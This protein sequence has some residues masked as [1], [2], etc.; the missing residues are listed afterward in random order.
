MTEYYKIYRSAEFVNRHVELD[1]IQSRLRQ[2][3][4]GAFIFEGERGAGKTSLMF[5]I[6]RQLSAQKEF[7]P[8]FIG[9]F[10]YSAPEF[11]GDKKV[12][13][14]EE[15]N[16][17]D[18]FQPGEMEALLEQLAEALGDRPVQTGN[19]ENKTEYLKEYLAR[20]LAR[21]PASA[22]PVL[23]VDSI[24]EADEN[25]RTDVEKYIVAPLLASGRVFVI[26]SGRGKR[27]VWSRPE[28]QNAE[29]AHLFPLEN[30]EQVREQLE[31]MKSKRIGEYETIFDLSGGYP[32]IVRVMGSSDKS[33]ELA[34]Y[35]ALEILIK[36]ALPENAQ[37]GQEFDDIRTQI[38]KLAL[39]QIPFRIPDV[40]NYLYELDP[41]GNTNKLVNTLLKSHILRH[42]GKGYLLNQSIA[43]PYRKWLSLAEQNRERAGL[44]AKL[45][46][47]SERLQAQY[48]AARSWY[49]QMVPA[50]G[51]TGGSESNSSNPF[52]ARQR[53]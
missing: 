35:D 7:T 23:L 30:K 50:E 29:I 18:N 43:R 45:A 17:R 39:V 48:P 15:K 21:N 8:F 14:R 2:N 16:G 19:S 34:L 52:K 20:D 10:R 53:A 24:Y 42:E 11:E 9:L 51:P 28:L 3:T 22:A 4:R 27:P 6:F 31:K 1:S 44:M 37:G 33:L 25:V 32:L 36:D 47:T 12:W 5:E 41:G 13:I 38:E 46:E 49:Q 40:E 26:L